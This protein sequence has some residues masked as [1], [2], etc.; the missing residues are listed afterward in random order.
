MGGLTEREF[1]CL[2]KF[3]SGLRAGSVPPG[4]LLH[5]TLLAA[6][7]AQY[8][9]YSPLEDRYGHAPGI[10]TITEQ[11]KRALIIHAKLQEMRP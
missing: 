6:G 7:R 5:E 9:F 11:G 1:A 10:W 4:D 8:R 3:G 2:R